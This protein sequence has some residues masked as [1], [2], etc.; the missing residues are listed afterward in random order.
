MRF[1][2]IRN[3]LACIAVGVALAITGAPAG[4]QSTAPLTPRS[5]VPAHDKLK[6]SYEI[7]NFRL[8]GKYNLDAAPE[9]WRDGGEG[10]TTLESLG[11]GPLRAAYIA[12][13]SPKRDDKGQIVNAVVISSFYSG[14][15]TASY[16]FWYEGQPG[17]AFAR[18]PVVG[19]GRAIDTDKFYVVFVDAI[20]LWGASKP[21]D[22]LGRKFP[23]YSSFDQ[24]Q[25]N[26]RLLRDHLK[27]ARVELATGVSMGGTQSWVWGVMYSPTGF[28]TA[29]MPIG[30]ATAADGGDPIG[31][32]TFRLAQAALESDPKWRA[33]DGNYYHLPPD[34]HP[35]QGL[36]FM[37]SVLQSTGWDFSTRSAQT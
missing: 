31:Q 19:P 27:V 10:G 32:W 1:L 8:G 26:Y 28:V 22:G 36:Q 21:S 29:I 7:A 25:A 24:V 12:V 2:F 3:A 17:N 30:G 16:N 33:T 6:Q 13:G 11:A 5:S 20:G 9:T 35:K 37:W 14:D 34:Q 18:G 15:A 4:A 23:M